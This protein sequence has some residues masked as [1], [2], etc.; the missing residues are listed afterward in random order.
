MKITPFEIKGN[1]CSIRVTSW[2]FYVEIMP[3]LPPRVTMHWYSQGWAWPDHCSSFLNMN[4]FA[5][6]SLKAEEYA[7]I[8]IYSTTH[9]NF[10]S[11]NVYYRS[12]QRRQ[13]SIKLSIRAI[14]WAVY[15]I[16][17]GRI[18][19]F[20]VEICLNRSVLSLEMACPSPPVHKSYLDPSFLLI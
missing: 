20:Y 11:I 5:D 19:S 18:I 14:S 16:S 17:T 2:L 8:K 12:G 9:T 6:Y 15:K 4:N 1:D 3:I 7:Y 10:Y 13:R